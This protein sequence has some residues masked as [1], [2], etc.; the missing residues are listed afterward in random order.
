MFIAEHGALGEPHVRTDAQQHLAEALRDPDHVKASEHGL[1][2]RIVGRTLA[3]TVSST[4]TVSS[5]PDKMDLHGGGSDART[6]RAT[7]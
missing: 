7:E 2:R 4:A 1:H 3:T 6:T 5:A